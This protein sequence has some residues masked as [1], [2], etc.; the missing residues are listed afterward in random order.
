MQQSFGV[1]VCFT[2]EGSFAQIRLGGGIEPV[3]RDRGASVR[4]VLV[5]EGF[6]TEF[7]GD[8]AV[9]TLVVR[10]REGHGLILADGL[11]VRQV[12]WRPGP[13]WTG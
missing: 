4:R 7:D 12:L 1:A 11:G 3:V 5:G 6:P 10:L 13:L 9:Q 2:D 8:P